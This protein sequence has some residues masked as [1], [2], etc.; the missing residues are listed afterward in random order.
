M[1]EKCIP[2]RDRHTD[3]SEV[4]SLYCM[5][6]KSIELRNDL[7]EQWQAAAKEV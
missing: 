3:I 1:E 2:T 7:Q 5:S 6:E 4:S